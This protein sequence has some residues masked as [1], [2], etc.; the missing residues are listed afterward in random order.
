MPSLGILSHVLGKKKN[1]QIGL[2]AGPLAL[3]MGPD[4]GPKTI[5][6]KSLNDELNSGLIYQQP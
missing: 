2:K 3:E 5:L 4:F 6:E 1:T